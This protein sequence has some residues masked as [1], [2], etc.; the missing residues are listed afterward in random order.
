MILIIIL[1]TTTTTTTTT[2]NNNTNNNNERP[3]AGAPRSARARP[4][5]RGR[6]AGGHP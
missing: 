2:T 5:A 4:G 3:E 1:Y 6:A